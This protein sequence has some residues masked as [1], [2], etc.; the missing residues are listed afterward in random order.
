LATNQTVLWEEVWKRTKNS[1]HFALANG[2]KQAVIF[3][4]DVHYLDINGNY[5]NSDLILHDEAELDLFDFPI[6]ADG[7]DLFEYK[8][9]IIKQVRAVDNVDREKCSFQALKLPFAVKL[10]RNWQKGY[11]VGKDSA[12]LIFIPVGASASVGVLDEKTKTSIHY[13]DA[14]NDTDV[15][16]EVTENGLKETL[17][18]KTSKSPT[19]FSFEVV[20]ELADDLT[21]GSLKLQPA[22]L[23]DANGARRDVLQ[24]VRREDIGVYLDLIAD[25]EGLVFPVIV[26]PTVE[27]QPDATSGK[28]TYISELSPTVNYGSDDVIS[29]GSDSTNPQRRA[30]LQFDLASIPANSSV[31]SAILALYLYSVST[32]I[33][34]NIT[35]HRITDSWD[36]SAVNWNIQPGHHTEAVGTTAVGA[37]SAT[38]NFTITSLV[39]LH[40]ASPSTNYGVMLK[41]PETTAS[42]RK[43]FRSSDYSDSTQ[44]PKLTVIYNVPPTA[45]TIIYP[46]GGET[47]NASEMIY[48][49]ASTDT[50]T[51]S[52]NL[53]YNIELSVDGGASYPYTIASLT[54]AGD[55]AR[56]HDFSA[57]PQSSTCLIRIRAYDGAL[58]GAW[59]VSDGVFTIQ[60][61]LAPTAPTFL[62]PSSGVIDRSLITRLSWQHNDPNADPQAQFDLMRSSD[63]GGNWVTTTQATTNQY[64][65]VPA[66]T[67]AHG[68][69]LW[70]VRTYDASGLSS[71]YSSQATFLAGNKPS[72]PTVYAP[73]G[74]IATASPTVQWSS[75]GQASYQIQALNSSSAV[76][77]DTGE[78]V[79]TNLARTLG[80]LLANSSDYT[81]KVRIKNV[82]GLWSDYGS[83]SVSVSYTPP[84]IPLLS[85]ST[86]T[87]Y[88]G[89]TST[90]P[91]PSGSQPAVTANDIYRREV[92]EASW[93]RISAGV[94]S[95]TG[96]NSFITS[97]FS[98]YMGMG[99]YYKD[100][101][102]ASGKLYEYKTTAKGDNGTES[103]SPIVVGVVTLRGV[104]LHDVTDPVG[105]AYNFQY[106]GFKNVSWQPEVVLMQF[107]GRKQTVVEF[108]E[109]ETNKISVKLQ[110]KSG[111][112]DYAMLQ[113]LV[114]RKPTF[115]YRDGRGRKMFGVVTTLPMSDERYGYTTSIEVTENSFNE[116]V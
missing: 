71:A 81:I 34:I 69:I 97:F 83:T 21:S 30:L 87:G 86:G 16:L 43:T 3:Q 112:L 29:A 13:Q 90:N 115:C 98:V 6:A 70:K 113:Y 45:P 59:D 96:Y 37:V 110:M 2:S 114:R 89:V 40:V 75:I 42:E 66:N 58:Y 23:Q 32:S 7:K 12:R 78:V 24:T 80:V 85:V 10:P 27:I 107:A 20:G 28:D 79:S 101:S 77:W 92:G 65:D 84:A 54:D 11:T 22:W 33:D 93:T 94:A 15:V 49:T 26:D 44:R 108:G 41:S 62:S 91:T 9:G 111:D 57:I 35:T 4:G 52:A 73:T 116:V 103:D 67:L 102:V 104:W 39:S 64:L 60:H 31:T 99:S 46:N 109:S 8:L 51:A 18:L 14:W 5:Q 68:T 48:W 47:W 1:K 105:T 74:T 106:D 76:I 63:S 55:I 53:M 17:T 25:V 36:E 19:I 100:Y 61:N 38:Y 72:T 82:D 56:L 95:S 50:E 88:I